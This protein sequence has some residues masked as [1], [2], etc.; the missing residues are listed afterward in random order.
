MREMLTPTA[1]VAG[2][3]L[4]KEVALLT[5]GRFSGATRGASIGHIS[6]EAAEGGTIALVAEG[7]TIEIDIPGR[8]LNILVSDELLQQRRERWTQPE[9]RVQSGCLARYARLVS[10]ASQ[11]AVLI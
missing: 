3:E 8:R 9:P 6:P 1:A 5:D 4:D 2:M 7:D 11:G 10:S